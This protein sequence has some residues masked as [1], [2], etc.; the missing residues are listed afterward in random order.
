MLHKFK[1]FVEKKTTNFQACI[2][3]ITSNFIPKLMYRW[4]HYD[5]T[6]PNY[7]TLKGYLNYTLTAYSTG[8]LEHPQGPSVT[9]DG[10]TVEKCQYVM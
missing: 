2:I 8:D 4:S 5:K 6:D 1:S 3:A 10:A 9:L 7:G